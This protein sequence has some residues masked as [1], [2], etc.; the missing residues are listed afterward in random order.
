[1]VNR[2]LYLLIAGFSFGMISCHN[3]Q[4]T[5][6]KTS[7][8]KVDSLTETYLTLQDSLLHAWNVIAWDEKEKTKAMHSL[9][10]LMHNQ[11]GFDDQQLIILEQR[12]DQLDRIRFTQKTLANAYVIEEYDFASNSLVTEILSLAEADPEFI[13]NENVQRLVDKVKLTDQRVEEYRSQYDRVASNFN[14]FLERNKKYLKEIDKDCTGEKQ[15]LF[16]MAYD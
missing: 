5:Q 1:M 15:A 12:L 4:G 2:A 14:Q 10:H 3:Q 9:L 8:T 7:F 6:H 13:K 11:K 16:Q